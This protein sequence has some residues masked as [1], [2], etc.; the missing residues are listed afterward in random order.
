VHRKKDK[1]AVWSVTVCIIFA[2]YVIAATSLATLC[3]QGWGAKG[4]QQ[5][6][7][8]AYCTLRMPDLWTFWQMCCRCCAPTNLTARDTGPWQLHTTHLLCC[9]ALR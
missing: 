6:P 2:H 5:I 1:T 4:K 3:R 8:K 9:P 7:G